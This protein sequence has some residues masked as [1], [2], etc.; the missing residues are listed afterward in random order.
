MSKDIGLQADLGAAEARIYTLEQTIEQMTDDHDR[1]MKAAEEREAELKIEIRELERRLYP[2]P[3]NM[4]IKDM[5]ISTRA[6]NA[7]NAHGVHKVSE[8]MTMSHND[9]GRIKNLGQKSG[10]EVM[11]QLKELT[12]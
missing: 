4:L 1:A 8:L 10:Y 7:L 3:E 6:K 11:E 9:I 5:N 2:V 12:Q